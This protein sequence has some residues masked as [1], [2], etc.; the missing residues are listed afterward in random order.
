MFTQF[1]AY[2]FELVLWYRSILWVERILGQLF[3]IAAKQASWGIR[4]TTDL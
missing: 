4:E 2:C 1:K 3:D